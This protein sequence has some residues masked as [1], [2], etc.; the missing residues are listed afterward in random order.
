MINKSLAMINVAICIAIF[1]FYASGQVTEFTY[2]GR[3]K[4]SGSPANATYDFEFA[5]FDAASGGSQIGVTIPKN[6]VTVT[7]G[8]FAVKLDFGSVFPG[9][10]RYL[11]V[12]V[13]LTGQPTLTPL[14]PRQLVNSSPYSIKTL[15]SDNATNATQ[16]GR[17]AANQYV[18]T[19]HPRLPH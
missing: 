15:N 2:Q 6:T 12:R 1:A 5:L 7:N 9:A 11:E 18:V 16:L 4:D 10:N 14:A 17:V 19:A 3:L 13:K 8:V